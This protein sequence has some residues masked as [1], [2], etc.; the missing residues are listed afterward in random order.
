M[1]EQG[2]AFYRHELSKEYGQIT[3]SIQAQKG[4]GWE[5]IVSALNTLGDGCVDTYMAVMGMV[6]ERNGV[7]KIRTPFELSPD[8]ILAFCGKKKSNGSYIA[9]QRSEVIKYLKTLS[10]AH[11]I[12]VIPSVQTRK[13][14]G[15]EVTEPTV[16]RAEG[17]IIDL[18]SFKMGEYEAIT[19]EE[20]WEQF[21]ISIGPWAQ[22]IPGLS[23]QTALMLR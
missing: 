15:K 2:I 4:E 6:I 11:V 3:I 21:S 23:M 14:R 1:K 9:Q 8:D 16:F 17:A 13:R 12:A 5:T 7:E 22:M 20:I 10:Q 19:G 18:L